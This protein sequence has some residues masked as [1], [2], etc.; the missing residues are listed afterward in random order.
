MNSAGTIL[1]ELEFVPA[2]MTDYH[3]LQRYHYRSGQ[4]GPI[5]SVFAIK[6][7]DGSLLMHD[8]PVAGVIVY[9]W[10]PLNCRM[11]NRVFADLLSGLDN[12]SRVEKVN[13]MVRTISRVIIEPR[14]RGLGL[15][16]KLVRETLSQVNVPIVEAMAA[17]GR[18]HPF[19]ERAGMTAYA[20]GISVEQA[21]LLAAFETVGIGKD[22]L[23]DSDAVQN[24]MDR[25]DGGKRTLIEQQI[26][27]FLGPRGKRR[28]S[29]PGTERTEYILSRLGESPVYFAKEKNA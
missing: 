20:T 29:Q 2:K 27:R 11:R 17:M 3:R 12:S 5:D 25:L 24:K 16:S 14:F 7:K 19:F 26:I 4:P 1:D 9:A 13:R 28:Y 23:L 8:C 6:P 10:P 18:V 21:R 22:N 15:A